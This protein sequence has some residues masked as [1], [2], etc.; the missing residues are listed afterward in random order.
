MINA[1][2]WMAVTGLV[3]LCAMIF[4]RRAVREHN[5]KGDPGEGIVLF[6]EPVRWL[7]VIWGFASFCNGLSRG[8]W[9]GQTRLFRWST[10]AGS[11][12]VV[13]DVVSQKRLRRRAGRLA[14]LVE[15]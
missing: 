13:P 8:G 3:W 12:L 15:Q 10:A 14:R 7:L 9:R 6:V 2:S 11:L 5:G 4:N 1:W